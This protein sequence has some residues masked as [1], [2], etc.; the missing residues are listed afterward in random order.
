MSKLVPSQ[1]QKDIFTFA[2]DGEGSAAVD[3]KAGSG[4][5]TTLETLVHLLDRK[6]RVLMVA[7]NKHI[8]VEME[9]RI[10]ALDN[11]DIRTM[12]SLGFRVL[13]SMFAGLGLR[14]PAVNGNKSSD[15]F[16]AMSK[17]ETDYDVRSMFWANRT[18]IL[19]LVGLAKS[20]GMAPEGP[21]AGVVL[22][23]LTPNTDQEWVRLMD[24][25]AIDADDA[26]FA[27]TIAQEILKLSVRAAVTNL[28]VIDF[29]DQ[30]WLP[31][32]MGGTFPKFDVILADEAQDLSPLNH[33]VLRRCCHEATRVIAVGDPNQGI[34]GF[35]GADSASMAK[36]ITMFDMRSLPL[37]ISY[38]CAASIV[39][40]AQ[41]LVP[42][43][44]A[45]DNAPEGTVC[46]WSWY[47][48]EDF[49]SDDMIMCRL[50]APL[51]QMAY[52]LIRRKVAVNVLGRD[53]GKGLTALIKK[54][55]RSRGA[56]VIRGPGGLAER[57]L[58]HI[59]DAQA[60]FKDDHD[61]AKLA[62]VEDKIETIKVFIDDYEGD[63]V[64]GL[65]REI[66]SLFSDTVD[67]R[68]TLS[69]VHKAKGLE[70]DRAFI[71][72]PD[73]MPCKWARTEWQKQQERN[74]EYVAITRAKTDLVFI[75][76]DDMVD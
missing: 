59:R 7:F 54:L 22:K 24:H 31:I 36:L 49:R 30:I 1:Y 35:R 75:R 45:A 19:K 56:K 8:V 64:D 68:L 52:A 65:M 43:I 40:Y 55:D 39:W 69:T 76:I 28:N 71:L 73:T 34:Y 33:E 37:S 50:N 29:D 67:S 51:I 12:N 21:V 2:R 46:G 61:E 44:E 38:R 15:I 13:L 27:I 16:Y 20:V 74:L 3:A 48:S 17:A 6:L 57:L 42:E 5:T 25:H 63:D 41:R 9:R 23:G 53:I 11:V 10:G 60:K 70:A 32:I 62:R 47:N 4:K 58:K 18:E 26:G 72:E 14:K 66:E